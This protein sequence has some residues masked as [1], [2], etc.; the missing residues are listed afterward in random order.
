MVEGAKL[1][2]K[3]VWAILLLLM[4]LTSC[5]FTYR[6]LLGVN[7]SP[8]FI[9][10]KKIKK[11][12][13]RYGVHK[14]QFYLL[15]LGVYGDTIVA[16]RNQRIADLEMQDSLSIAPI[17]MNAKND[18]QPVQ[19]RYFDREGKPIFKMVNCYV[20]PPI[21]MNWNVD[22]SLDQ[23][24]PQP[25]DELKEDIDFDLEFFLPM[26]KDID[27]KEIARDDLPVADFY[28]IIFW[29]SFFIRPSKKLIKQ[30]KRYDRKKGEGR[31]H[32]LFVNNHNAHLYNYLTDEDKAKLIEEYDLA[33]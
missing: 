12:A 4:V 14:D 9:S 22:G 33:P 7:I 24:P 19:L 28:A 21:P 25:I 11:K 2:V 5:K 1:K 8:D 27:G 26:I 23:F 32:F 15:E 20:D 3:N 17:K 6:T 31:T 18:A 30:I 29:N 10:E 16:I 13:K